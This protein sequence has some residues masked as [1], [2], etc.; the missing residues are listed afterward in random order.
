VGGTNSWSSSSA[1]YDRHAFTYLA[2]TDADRFAV[3]AYVV[4]ELPG[5][6]TSYLTGLHQFE[7]VNKQSPSSASLQEAG[8]VA[9]PG[10]GQE[11]A[12]NRAFIDGDAVYFVRDAQVFGTYWNTPTQVN[13]PF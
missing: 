11:A 6:T 5:S 8:V 2:G 12:L 3:P 9:T 10:P 1:L 7:I 4:T 13:G